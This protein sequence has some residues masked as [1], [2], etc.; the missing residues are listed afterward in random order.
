MHIKKGKN[1]KLTYKETRNN[2]SEKEVT[3]SRLILFADEALKPFIVIIK[4][5]EKAKYAFSSYKSLQMGEFAA[6]AKPCYAGKFK[7][8]DMIEAECIFPITVES[9]FKKELQLASTVTDEK[10]YC[11]KFETKKF[12]I[13]D[14]VDSKACSLGCDGH[15]LDNCYCFK[16]QRQ[17]SW[18]LGLK[19]GL[20]DYPD[21]KFKPY[22][23]LNLTSKL[24]PERILEN[25]GKDKN[26][27]LIVDS[28]YEHVE[29]QFEQKKVMFVVWFKPSKKEGSENAFLHYG[30]ITNIKI[31]EGEPLV[32]YVPQDNADNV[33]WDN[34]DDVSKN[35]A[36]ATTC[37]VKI[38]VFFRV[39]DSG[40]LDY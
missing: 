36:D 31:I 11:Y 25:E 23:S 12:Y 3:Y 35:N 6:I 7:N 33:P 24:V 40:L 14:F 4:Q 17:E 1:K 22:Y 30:N 32:Q 37:W 13:E 16:R 18:I 5:D 28:I 27:K 34:A 2:N 39:F 10:Y 15:Y 21:V 19:F 8:T 20:D 29:A 26:G 9:S 38:F